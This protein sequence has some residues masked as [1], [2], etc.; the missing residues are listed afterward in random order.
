ML[1]MG[2]AEFKIEVVPTDSFLS[3]GSDQLIFQFA[4]NKGSD[5]G[6]LKKVASGG[7]LSRIML[8]IKSIL[9]S[10]EKLP[11][12]IFDEIDTGVS[13]EISNKM[14]GI[15]KQMGAQMQLF[16][17]TH[18]PQVAS[19]GQQQLKVYKEE[20]AQSTATQIKQLTEAE[21]IQELAEMLG[22][23]SYADSAISH[24]KEL[25]AQG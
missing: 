6:E 25:L 9:A 3:N 19:Q 4:A 17:I 24:A 11:T 1:G 13:G 8:A 15:M 20:T 10:Y 23:K 18:L 2:A 22:G 5:F 12:L 7:E 14:G 16:S 21:R